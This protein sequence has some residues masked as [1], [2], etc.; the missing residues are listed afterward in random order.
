VTKSD[1]LFCKLVTKEI[2]TKV[3]Y[4]DDNLIAIEDINPAAPV[5]LLII[6][7]EHIAGLN[8]ITESHKDLLGHI[9]LVAS[10]LAKK[11]GLSEQGYRLLT[12]CGKWGGQDILHIHYH[13][14]GGRELG[15]PPG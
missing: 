15:W 9:Q 13:L 2:P 14:L 6:P 4:E 12:N 8:D 11:F 3:V 1:C 10:N 5:H 7:R